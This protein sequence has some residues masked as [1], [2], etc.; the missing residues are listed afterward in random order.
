MLCD[1]AL[2]HNSLWK[3][4]LRRCLAPPCVQS[5]AAAGGAGSGAGSED[6]HDLQSDID[7]E[8]EEDDTDDFGDIGPAGD[9]LPSEEYTMLTTCPSNIIGYAVAVKWKLEEP[10]RGWFVG[11]VQGLAER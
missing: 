5:P 11:K 2:A 6:E 4:S 9:Y 1:I 10:R 3:T 8:E 7:S